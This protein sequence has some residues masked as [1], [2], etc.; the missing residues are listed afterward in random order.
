MY[1]CFNIN[2]DISGYARIGFRYFRLKKF[3][4]S[5]NLQLK[6]K[7]DRPETCLLDE[8]KECFG[9]GDIYRLFRLSLP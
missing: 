3:L 7:I 4:S 9:Y 1:G 5:L 8:I 6:L 2:M